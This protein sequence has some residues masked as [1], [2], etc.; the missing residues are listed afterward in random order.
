MKRAIKIT[1]GFLACTLLFSNLNSIDIT[2]ATEAPTITVNSED[3]N[4]LTQIQSFEG[5]NYLV[6]TAIQDV[7]NMAVR[8]NVSNNQTFVFKH[9]EL[10]KGE[11]VS[12]ELDIAEQKQVIPGKK[13]LP[14]TDIVREKLEVK[15]VIKGFNVVAIVSYDV[16]KNPVIEIKDLDSTNELKNDLADKSDIESKDKKEEINPTSEVVKGTSVAEEAKKVEDAQAD[17]WEKA[18]S[19]LNKPVAVNESRSVD[20]QPNVSLSK[21]D[22]K[23]AEVAKKVED[24][25]AD[26][27]EKAA[28]VNNASNPNLANSS[29]DANILIDQLNKHRIA[30]GKTPLSVDNSLSEGTLV[31]ANEFAALAASGRTG[32]SLHLRLDGSSFSTA[33][34]AAIRAK[35]G[36]NVSYGSRLESLMKFWKNSPAHNKN[37]LSDEY[38]KVSIKVVKQNGM[39]YG[40]QIFSK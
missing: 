11:S 27:W 25:Q 24:A 36:E 19:E 9:S 39:Y 21:E 16:E 40:V 35:L 33:F 26:A 1:S 28:T 18:A 2:K 13:I 20:A 37:M 8:V 14:K 15:G 32:M 30:N 7:T 22:V 23:P 31:R 4:I 38:T 3:S 10:N 17:A 29:S 12:F 6:V 34:P 5:K